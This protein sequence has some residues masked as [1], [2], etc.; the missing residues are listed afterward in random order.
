MNLIPKEKIVLVGIR[1][2]KK[3]KYQTIMKHNIK[4]FTIE[5]VDKYGIGNVMKQAIEYLD[6]KSNVPLHIFLDVDCWIV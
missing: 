1:D 5:D 4:A 6:S 3:A 2:I